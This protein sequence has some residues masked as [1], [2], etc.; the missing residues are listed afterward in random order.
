MD[1][2]GDFSWTK[3]VTSRGHLWVTFR[4]HFW[5]T[6]RGH[7]LGDFSWTFWVT[8]RGHFGV[9]SRGHYR[10]KKGNQNDDMK[11]T[12]YKYKYDVRTWLCSTY[13]RIPSVSKMLDNGRYSHLPWLVFYFS[14][15]HLTK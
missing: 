15:L 6:F 1:I 9:N 14:I 5:V 13:K 3:G 11:H 2:K 12:L 7:F 8:F 4:G 10:I